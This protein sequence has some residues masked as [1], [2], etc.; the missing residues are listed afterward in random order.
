MGCSDDKKPDV[1][2]ESE[3][4]LFDARTMPEAYICYTDNDTTIYMWD[5]RPVAYFKEEGKIYHFNG[6]FLGWYKD[7]VLYN[8][9]GYAVAARKGVVR[10]EIRM[11]ETYAESVVKGVKHSKPVP[12]VPSLP[13]VTPVFKDEWSGTSLSGFF[14]S[15]S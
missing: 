15:E 3:V 1:Q 9:E 7:K 10:G 13:P 6:S 8:K 12:H 4:T 2:Q 5:G 14:L 11:D